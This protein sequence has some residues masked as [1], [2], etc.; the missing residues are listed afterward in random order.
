MGRDEEKEKERERDGEVIV[1]DLG[2]SGK[3]KKK[4]HNAIKRFHI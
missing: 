4:S 2:R 3:K 1:K